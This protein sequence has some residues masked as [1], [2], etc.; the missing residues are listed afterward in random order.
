MN[1]LSWILKGVLAFSL[2]TEAGMA[3]AAYISGSTGADGAFNPT[4][5]QS[6]QLPP[7]GVFNFTDVNIPADV[8]ITFKKNAANTP[9]TI[10]ASGDVTIA[11]AIDV[12]ATPPADSNDISGPGIGGPGG[13]NGGRGG[14]AGGDAANW[15]NGLSGP[16]IGRAG[17]GPGGGSP[18]SYSTSTPWGRGITAGGG[19]AYGTAPPPPSGNCPGTPGS[20]YGNLTLLPLVGGSGGGGGVGGSLLPG[21]GG[22]GGGG[23]ILI[24]AS[25][26]INVAG[27][28]LA[29]GGRVAVNGVNGRG[30][31][32]GGGSGGAIRLI[33]TTISGNG[34]ISAAGGTIG[35][36][37][38]A[39]QSVGTTYTICSNG[40]IGPSNG[41][42]G[43]IRLESETLT[44]TAATNPLY[45]GGAPSILSIPG[46]P[47]LAIT[48]IAGIPV[49]AAPTGNGDVTIP[50]GAPNPVTVVFTTQGVTVGSTIKLTVAPPIGIAITAISAPTTGTTDNATSSV[51]IDIPGGS[52]ILQASVTYTVVASLGDAMSNYAQG[53]RVERVRLSSVLGGPSTATL[54]TVS[55]KEFTVPSGVLAGL[56]G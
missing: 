49:P 32:G 55:G 3:M 26:T 27:A 45:V 51:A 13:Y 31:Q 1:K 24:A 21:W 29:N 22:G 33:A 30:S 44:R 40:S 28:I 17:N 46:A 4:A 5:S 48:S 36:G 47:A 19:G 35:G 9:V 25:G 52:S 34:T 10:L 50:A 56:R 14:Q 8:T 38:L 2:V 7:N 41:G 39:T 53:E 20:A 54:I 11:G 18:G 23:A 15:V 16:N 37:E 43:R 6:I 42:A 12:S